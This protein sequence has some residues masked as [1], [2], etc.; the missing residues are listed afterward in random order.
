MAIAEK[1][2]SEE[3]EWSGTGKVSVGKVA[4]VIRYRELIRAMNGLKIHYVMESDRHGNYLIRCLND[5]IYDVEEEV[6]NWRSRC[7]T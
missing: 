2:E 5:D 7:T 6:K 4:G 1:Y 3:Q